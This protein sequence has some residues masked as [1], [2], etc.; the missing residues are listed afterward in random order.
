VVDRLD[1]SPERQKYMRD[2]MR[3][4]RSKDKPTPSNLSQADL[5]SIMEALAGIAETQRVNQ[6]RINDILQ[7]RP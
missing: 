1:V 5:L 4:R 6:E 3:R 7:T 2:Y